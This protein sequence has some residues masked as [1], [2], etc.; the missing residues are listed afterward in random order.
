MA[1]MMT[2]LWLDC[3]PGHDDALALVLAAFAPSLDLIGVSTVGGNQSVAKTTANAAAVLAMLG[4]TPTTTESAGPAAESN[5]EE[6]KQGA[7]TKRCVLV[8]GADKP[9]LAPPRGACAEIH[10]ECGLGGSEELDA[11]RKLVA[12]D[13]GDG[14][15]GRARGEM[16]GPAAVVMATEMARVHAETGRKITLVATGPLTN[17]ALLFS[18]FPVKMAQ[19]LER[20]VFMGGASTGVGNTSPVAEFNIQMD[21]TAAAMVFENCPVPLH[22]VPL[23]VTH[24][25]LYDESQ[26]ARLAEM[27][28]TP[29]RKVIHS[30]M[31]FFAS[32]YRE[33]F[34]FDAPPVHDPVAIF[35]VLAPGAFKEEH[36]RVDVET[37]R[38]S[39]CEGQT[40]VDRWHSSGKA[41]N[42]WV[43]SSAAPR[44]SR[45]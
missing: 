34:G 30:L 7:M 19:I 13:V 10:G 2:P 1:D 37:A 39:L 42:V 11:V 9:L 20:V 15:A 36:F 6:T 23:E 29:F 25:V 33:V 18:L 4:I 38:G 12:G 43:A 22:M 21:P 8:R 17:V 41:P 24:T 5:G 35:R 16:P 28:D 3:D 14:L 31:T 26:A 44:P 40:V 32:T 27:D 45:R